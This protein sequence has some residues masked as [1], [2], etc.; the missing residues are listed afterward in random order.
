MRE[1]GFTYEE[2]HDRM[3]EA[4]E[5]IGIDPDQVYVGKNDFYDMQRRKRMVEKERLP[6]VKEARQASNHLEAFRAFMAAEGKDIAG[7]SIMKDFVKGDIL[8]EVCI[9][10]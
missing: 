7:K 2:I 8:N 9:K 10:R 6:S 5:S 4:L 3:C 1:D